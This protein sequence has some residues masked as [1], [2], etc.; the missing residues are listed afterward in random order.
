M[1][2]IFYLHSVPELRELENQ[3]Q[4][5]IDWIPFGLYLGIKME[6][7]K[8]IEK[9][10]PK[11]LKRCRTEMFYEWQKKVT[12]TWSAVVQALMGIG[13]RRLASELAQKHG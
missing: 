11:D 10:Y 13:M 3:L 9:N 1:S 12:S 7:L 5:V 8:I 2:L 4:D 6:E